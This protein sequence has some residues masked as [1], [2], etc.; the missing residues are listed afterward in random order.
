MQQGL[1]LFVWTILA[2]TQNP[3]K[4]MQNSPYIAVNLSQYNLESMEKSC[5][6]IWALLQT[7]IECNLSIKNVNIVGMNK[8]AR[9]EHYYYVI[10]Q[11]KEEKTLAKI[12]DQWIKL[13][14]PQA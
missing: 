5:N 10:F 6:Q 9:C 1:D 14:F 13:Y 11:S 8:D 12:H 3:S 7:F 4:T 2:K